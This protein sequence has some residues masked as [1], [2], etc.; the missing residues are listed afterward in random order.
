MMVFNSE[1]LQMT[2]QQFRKIALS[3]SDTIESQHMGHPDFRVGGKI[4]A[5]L[6]APSDEFGMVKLTPEQQ[7]AYCDADA[8]A[9]QPCNGAW[10]RQGCTYV[11][12]AAVKPA[13]VRS[14][15]SLAVENIET[16]QS[17]K[18]V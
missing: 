3:L 17:R 12:L 14:A 16:L 6:G 18:K 8:N 15:L 5:S 1:V 13:I 7:K 2:P 11:K 4:F 9:F 10:G